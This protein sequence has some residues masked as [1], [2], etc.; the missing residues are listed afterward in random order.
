MRN[1]GFQGRSESLDRNKNS[2]HKELIDLLRFTQ[3]KD[4]GQFEDQKKIPYWGYIT[5]AETIVP[6]DP[7]LFAAGTPDP[8]ASF[9]FNQGIQWESY[10]YDDGSIFEGTMTEN[11]PHG[12]GVLTLGYLGGGGLLSGATSEELQFGDLF[13]GEFN[14]GFVHGV[15]KYINRDGFVFTGEFMAGVK[16]GCGELKDLSS[17]L[18]RIQSGF[19]PLKAW[20]LSASQ[21]ENTK[22]QGTWLNDYFSVGPDT[23]FKGAACTPSE[24]YGVLEEAEQVSNKARLFRYKPDGMAQIFYQ[25]A[26]GIPV[27]TLQ[28]P[29]HY[30]YGTSFLAPGPLAQMFP[31]PDDDALK[32]EML[33]AQNFWRSIYDGYNFDPNPDIDCTFAYALELWAENKFWRL[34]REEVMAKKKVSKQRIV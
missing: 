27:R 20:Q 25:D 15:G 19:D 23:E 32:N 13:E 8:Y 6:D 14:L 24:I 22:K 11:F 2:N 3:L 33:R 10:Y 26:S 9:S 5:S 7:Q 12:K 16:H 28:D 4:V 1:E 30:P 31:L 21:I 29:L 18:K 17:Y 34:Q